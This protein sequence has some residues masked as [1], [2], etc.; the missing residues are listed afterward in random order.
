MRGEAN[1]VPGS[2]LAKSM[3]VFG[4]VA[5]DAVTSAVHRVLAKPRSGR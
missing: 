3:A 2:V 5:P 1:V 4:T